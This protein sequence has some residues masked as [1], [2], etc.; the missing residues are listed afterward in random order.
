MAASLLNIASVA[1][2]F[3]STSI[4]MFFGGKMMNFVAIGALQNVC[5]T[6]IAEVSPLAIRASAIGFCNLA[7]CIG[8][9]ICAILSYYSAQWETQ[10]AWRAL[11]CAQWGFG[12]VALCGQ[13]FIPESPV[14]LVRKGRMEAARKSLGRMYTLPSDADGHLERIKYTLEEAG[15]KQ[16]GRYIDCFRGPNLRR[17]LISIL[18]FCSEPM[19]G[20]GFV[21]SYGAL[22]YQYL[23][24]SSHR[25]FLLQIGAQILSMS[26]ATFALFISDFIGRRPNYVIGC[27]AL[28]ALLLCMGISGSVTTAAATTASVGFYTM[29][30]FFYNISVGS[31]VYTLAGELP[32]SAL[33]AKSLAMSLNVSHAVNTMWSFVCPYI[34]NPDYGNLKAKIGFVFGGFMLIWAVLG[35]FW[36]PETRRRSYEELDELFMNHVPAR[37]FRTYVT[38]AQRRAEEA[39]CEEKKVIEGERA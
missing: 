26:G 30:N 1:V 19:A 3:S 8:P 6:Y 32:T 34:F 4:G 24:I 9:F 27:A 7:Q 35:Y 33:R 14:F 36:V 21:G 5:T 12:A 16:S 13:V 38:V 18:V 23:G 28:A 11:I 39:L 29:F 20:L 37:Q 31:T 10:W 17:T 22:M 15:T 25:S 2:E